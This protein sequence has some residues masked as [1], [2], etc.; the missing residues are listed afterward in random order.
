MG[1]PL[2][3]AADFL[4]VRDMTEDRLLIHLGAN[5]S[6]VYLPATAKMIEI[7]AFDTGPGNRFLDALV[8]RGS[9][10]KEQCDVGGHRAVQGR[11]CEELLEAWSRHHYFARKPP[12]TISRGEFDDIFVA[13]CIEEAQ[14]RGL[15]LNDLLCTATHFV[16][17]G[18]GFGVRQF[19][20]TKLRSIYLSGGGTRNGFLRQLLA[21][22]F[23]GETLRPTDDLGLPALARKAAAAAVLAGLTLDGVTGSLPQLTGAAGGRLIGRIVA[24]RSAELGDGCRLGRRA[25]VGL[26]LRRESRLIFSTFANPL[27]RVP[28]HSPPTETADLWH[29]RAAETWEDFR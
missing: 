6:F 4:L 12:K 7:V 1:G 16:T 28:V 10:E 17:R 14:R 27:R 21:Q 18:I 29:C 19:L 23:P 13:N 5:A 11:L 24:W 20:P 15:G 22:Q 8:Q 9:R 25:N 3:P 2:T 26:R